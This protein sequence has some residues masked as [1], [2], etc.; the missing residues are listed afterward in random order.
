MEGDEVVV[1][2]K[3]RADFLEGSF[4]LRLLRRVV[5]RELF[6]SI[7]YFGSGYAAGQEVRRR[8]IGAGYIE[9]W[10]AKLGSAR[11]PVIIDEL[12]G[13]DGALYTMEFIR[14]FN[15]SRFTWWCEAPRSYQVLVDF[16]NMLLKEAGVRDCALAVADEVV[17][18]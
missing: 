1:S 18:E 10:L 15:R 3:C 4:E 8:S 12:M 5:G 13:C 11:I 6:F 17:D 14:G 9:H 2:L 7:E 16:G